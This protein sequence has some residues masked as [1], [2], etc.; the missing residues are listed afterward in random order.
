MEISQY[1]VRDRDTV[2]Q[3]LRLGLKDQERYAALLDPP[4]DNGFFEREWREHEDGLTQEPDNWWVARDRSRP[5]PTGGIAGILWMRYPTDRLG[6][7]A[8]VREIDVHP[9]YRNKGIGT[10]LL[11]HAEQLSRSTDA[12]M[13]LISALITNPAVRLYQRLGFTDFPDHYKNDKNPNHVVL[14]K[15]FRKDLIKEL[16][17]GQSPRSDAGDRMP[18]P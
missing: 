10:R 14:W 1:Q 11:N 15:P 5:T 9:E 4:E 13:L 18:Q 2:L 3:V 6:P 7:Y 12:V 8:T 16:T 17:S